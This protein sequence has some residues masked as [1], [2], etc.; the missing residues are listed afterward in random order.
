[1]PPAEGDVGDHVADEEEEAVAVHGR[2]VWALLH[3]TV[4]RAER[5]SLH[6]DL[7]IVSRLARSARQ[8]R[9]VPLP[10][11]YGHELGERAVLLAPSIASACR[12]GDVSGREKHMLRKRIGLAIAGGVALSI[13]GAI[14]VSAHPGHRSC[15][16]FGQSVRASA[17]TLRP[18]GQVLRQVAPLNDDVAALH[19]VE[20]EPAP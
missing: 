6:A 3:V 10:D 18:Y 2:L 1:M 13:A 8:G 19:S 12:A 14:P 15:K 7:A 9:T 5:R 4:R 20:C 16:N 11:S 17:Q